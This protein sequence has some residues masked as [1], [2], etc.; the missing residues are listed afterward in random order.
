M[1]H[2]LSN[3]RITYYLHLSYIWHILLELA[4]SRRILTAS[5]DGFH[6]CLTRTDRVDGRAQNIAIWRSN[7]GAFELFDL[8]PVYGISRNPGAGGQK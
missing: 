4:E 6:T 2:Y 8:G 5:L 1:Y 7:C 3:S